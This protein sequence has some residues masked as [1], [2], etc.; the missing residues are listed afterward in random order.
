MDDSS[1]ELLAGVRVV[2]MAVN[3]PGPVAAHRLR[4]LGASVTKVEPP[5]GDPLSLV[6]P[7]YYAHLAAGQDVVALD[8]KSTAG[9]ERLHTLLQDADLLVT[10]HRPRALAAL[11]LDWE[12][13]HARHPHLS[14]VAITGSPG[15]AAD[16]PGHDLTYQAAAG[17]IAR[18]DGVPVMPTLPAADL[19]GAERAV[20]DGIAAVLRAQ[21]TGQGHHV[22]VA[23]SG[24][25][26][27]FAA[28]T[29]CGLSGPGTIL[30]G[31]YPLY[32]IYPASDGFVAVAA[33]E[34]HFAAALAALMGEESAFEVT[35][36]DLREFFAAGTLEHWSRW[37]REHD[38]PVA[39][40]R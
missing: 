27:D 21:R 5:S 20:A 18:H 1:D 7:E 30:G 4:G 33:I 11:G 6:A 17:T 32:G 15:E 34:P 37:A 12:D 35:A 8:L 38:L 2:S 39:P 23:L 29:R 31:G 16:T 3:L 36:E 9:S 22:E 14:Q 26:D 24:V 19:G 25:V 13:L 10:S 40:L 28:S